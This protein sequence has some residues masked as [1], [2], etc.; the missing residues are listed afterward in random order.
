MHFTYV[1]V[2]LA[3]LV[4]VTLAVLYKWQSWLNSFGTMADCVQKAIIDYRER[5]VK[6]EIQPEASNLPSA[7]NLTLSRWR[8]READAHELGDLERSVESSGQ[9]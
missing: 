1:L 2:I 7:W 4:G 9:R 5:K 8:F 3:V 6:E